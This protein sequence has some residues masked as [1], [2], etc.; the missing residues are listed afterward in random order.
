MRHVSI[1]S[2][3][4]AAILKICL[5]LEGSHQRVGGGGGRGGIPSQPVKSLLG[6]MVQELGV[7]ATERLLLA[8][9]YQVCMSVEQ[10]KLV[11]KHLE[12]LTEK[13]PAECV[14][15]TNIIL[16]SSTTICGITVVALSCWNASCM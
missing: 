12:D 11:S 9:S 10:L 3:I 8:C 13:H 15:A 2:D 16:I 6:I 4:Y 5:C 7:E 14:C 1:F